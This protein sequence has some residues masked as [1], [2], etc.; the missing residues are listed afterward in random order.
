MESGSSGHWGQLRA[1][2]PYLNDAGIECKAVMATLLE[3]ANFCNTAAEL[4]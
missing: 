2:E 4:L 1:V 3:F